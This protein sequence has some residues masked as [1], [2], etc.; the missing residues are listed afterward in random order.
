[1]SNVIQLG[2]LSRQ[3]DRYFWVDPWMWDLHDDIPDTVKRP[4][5][6][7][8]FNR[9][10]RQSRLIRKRGV[11]VNLSPLHM[12]LMRLEQS[13]MTANPVPD[14]V[15][16]WIAARVRG[17]TPLQIQAMLE[18]CSFVV[19]LRDVLSLPPLAIEWQRPEV[20]ARKAA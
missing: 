12:Q 1:M 11:L 2:L 3:D 8:A 9:M 19:L 5:E 16:H 17:F 15:Y 20:A 4:T 18:E 13:A 7:L 14:N 10:F 6:I